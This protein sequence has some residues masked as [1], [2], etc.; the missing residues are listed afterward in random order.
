MPSR[1]ANT[2]VTDPNFVSASTGD[3]QLQGTS[4]AVDRGLSVGYTTDLK[5]LSVPL[6]GNGD[7]RAVVDRG[8]YERP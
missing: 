1:G 3:L 8:V 7:G 5:G 6:D 2:L 4:P